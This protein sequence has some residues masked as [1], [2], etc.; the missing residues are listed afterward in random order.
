MQTDDELPAAEIMLEALILEKVVQVNDKLLALDDPRSIL[1][2]ELY[3]SN[4]II[5]TAEIISSEILEECGYWPELRK[6]VLKETLIS[7]RELERIRNKLN[8]LNRWQYLIERPIQLYESKRILYR[9]QKGSIEKVSITEPRDEELRR[10]GWWQQQIALLV[11]ARDALAP[12]LQTLVK[13]L[14]DLMFV[15]L[16]QIIGKSIGLI[17]RGIAQGMGRNLGRS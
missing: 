17:G 2:I 9:F 11:E 7:T 8:S 16:T 3:I 12:Q 15:I 13:R 10:L 4:W 5:R 1:K 6:Y 14:G